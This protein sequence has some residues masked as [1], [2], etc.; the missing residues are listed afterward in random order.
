MKV[1]CFHCLKQ[2]KTWTYSLADFH[3]WER[4]RNFIMRKLGVQHATGP[5]QPLRVLLVRRSNHRFMLN[6]K[7][8]LKS[9][10]NTL[11][12]ILV[13]EIYFEKINLT[14]R[15]KYASECDVMVGVDGSGLFN[16]NFMR[17]G[18]FVVRILPYGMDK[19][20]PNKGF[21]FIRSWNALGVHHRDLHTTN[22]RHPYTASSHV[23]CE[24]I[25]TRLTQELLGTSSIKIRSS[26][27]LVWS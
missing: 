10:K 15:I 13:E 9:I 26:T 25:R 18:S 14:A 2:Q 12:D 8:V 24:K 1:P 21:N 5:R 23:C 3:G 16:A 17:K 27:R 6:A 19:Y 4:F 11:K 7:S 20:L 22:A